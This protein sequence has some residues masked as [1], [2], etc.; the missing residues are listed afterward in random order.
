MSAALPDDLV[1]CLK[2]VAAAL[3]DGGVP[4]ALGGGLA[5]WARGGPR[6][7]HD[8]DLLVAGDDIPDAQKVLA[9]SGFRVE[10]PPE[11]WLFKAFDDDILIDVIH[12]P[13]GIVI[14][15]DYIARCDRLSVAAVEMPVMG[16]DD[17]MVTKLLSLNEHCLDLGRV[18]Q[19]SRAL[20]EQITWEDVRA[21]TA[22]SPFADAFFVLIT[23]LCIVDARV[24]EA[25]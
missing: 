1:I 8:V 15:A 11:D 16:L 20:R 22:E 19:V 12:R 10:L 4:F 18:L 24:L 5:A 17:L 23:R 9:E 6:S 14:D 21:R 3:R 13:S 25:A 2:R 7:E